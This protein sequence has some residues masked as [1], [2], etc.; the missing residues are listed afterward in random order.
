MSTS[1]VLYSLISG[2]KNNLNIGK[3][4]FKSVF[5]KEIYIIIYVANVDRKMRNLMK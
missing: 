3:K 1:I 2:S 4:V 5:F